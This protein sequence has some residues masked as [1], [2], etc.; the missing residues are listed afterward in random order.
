[1][2]RVELLCT[3]DKIVSSNLQPVSGASVLVKLR[4]TGTPVTVYAGET[5][6]A[7][8]SNPLVTDAEGRVN[9][10]VDEGSLVLT[11]SGSGI[12]SYNQPYEAARAD[13]LV[14]IDGA[15]VVAGSMPGTAITNASIPDTKLAVGAVTNR[16]L[17]ESA[18]PLGT[19][20]A[21]WLPAK[22]GGGYAIPT[23]W[24][25][26][27]G[28]TLIAGQHDFVGGGSVTLPNLID[29]VP[30][31]TDPT[32]AYGGAAGMNADIGA[33][34][35]NLAHVH[36]HD[37]THTIASHSHQV[38]DHSHTISHVHSVVVPD[39][40]HSV[41]YRKIT[42]GSGSYTGNFMEGGGTYGSGAIGCSVGGPSSGSSGGSGVLSTINQTGGT[43][44][45]SPSS[46]DTGSAGS[47]ATDIRNASVG[48]L[49]L[50]R[51]KNT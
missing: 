7:T 51:V 11:I 36:A 28:Q 31:G 35:L 44:T 26:C 18:L 37:H 3:V 14:A 25:V 6:G 34:T 22:P 39:H 5:G 33:N 19:I 8:V 21:L 42:V 46:T 9:G 4:S 27:N 20:I 40:A 38:Q 49:Y 17:A 23:G 13:Q 45:G 30:R 41:P 29:K 2:A 16:H 43:I 32:L 12:T 47:A 15:R 1:M 48:V 50:I 10:W 24:A